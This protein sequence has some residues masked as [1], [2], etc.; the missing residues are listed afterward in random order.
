MVCHVGGWQP[1]VFETVPC[2]QICVDLISL[3]RQ[4]LEDDLEDEVQRV[5]DHGWYALWSYWYLWSWIPSKEA[6]S[7]DQL[8]SEGSRV[9]F[10]HYRYYASW[11]T[12]SLKRRGAGTKTIAGSGLRNETETKVTLYA[13]GRPGTEKEC[14]SSLRWRC[15]RIPN[16]EVVPEVHPDPRHEIVHLAPAQFS[17]TLVGLNWLLLVRVRYLFS[18]SPLQ[19]KYF[20]F[21]CYEWVK[22]CV[23]LQHA[24]SVQFFSFFMLIEINLHAPN[25]PNGDDAHDGATNAAWPRIAQFA[26]TQKY[27]SGARCAKCSDVFLEMQ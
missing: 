12:L 10:E 22:I 19:I 25:K 4:R 15:W 18:H 5:F 21:T 13:R 27:E 20:P 14:L 23:S 17:G 7:E 1:R 6:S 2:L 11:G 26:G 16:T 3:W 8:L 9:W 24:T